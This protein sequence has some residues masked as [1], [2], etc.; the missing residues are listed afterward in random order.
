MTDP[1][2]ALQETAPDL[3]G[4]TLPRIAED[5]RMP[6]QLYASGFD[7]TSRRPRV[8]LV[9]A[10]IGLNAALSEQAIRDLPGGVTLAVSPYAED[11]ERLLTE[12]R[13]A[14]HEYLL[15]IP[16]ELESFR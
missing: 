5:G 12:A 13:M 3:P 14:E 11:P 1:E 16:M 2:P 15:S 6:M 10:G 9:L 4:R 8:G 7:Q